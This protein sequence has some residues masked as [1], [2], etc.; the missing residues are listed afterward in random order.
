[1]LEN[2]V[3]LSEVR[4]FIPVI[5]FPSKVIN[6]DHLVV[7]YLNSYNYGGSVCSGITR[8]LLY[9]IYKVQLPV[10]P[11]ALLICL[12]NPDCTV[13]VKLNIL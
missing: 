8:C 1:M 9:R 11:Q 7:K 10:P 3:E 6:R 5:I 13:I 4:Q 12:F 2:M